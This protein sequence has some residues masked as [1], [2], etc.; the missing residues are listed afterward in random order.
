MVLELDFKNN[1]GRILNSKEISVN[2]LVNFIQSV[3]N[4]VSFGASNL[5][6]SE[7]ITRCFNDSRM[8]D[9]WFNHIDVMN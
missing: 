5:T 6:L 1:V 2:Q 3:K 7:L 9:A 8:F 4:D